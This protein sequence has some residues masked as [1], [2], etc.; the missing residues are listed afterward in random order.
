MV[1][2]VQFE[3]AI[4]SFKQCVGAAARADDPCKASILRERSE[5]Y[6]GTPV[7]FLRS[8]AAHLFLCAT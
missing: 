2:R 1:Y 6:T 8:Y 4:N 3:G 7:E 5:C